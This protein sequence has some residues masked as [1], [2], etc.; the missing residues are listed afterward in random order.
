[1]KRDLYKETDK[2]AQ[3]T[4]AKRNLTHTLS[5]THTHTTLMSQEIDVWCKTNT[6]RTIPLAL[7]GAC[8]P[9]AK[10]MYYVKSTHIYYVKKTY[11]VYKRGMSTLQKRHI[12]YFSD[13]VWRMSACRHVY[14]WHNLFYI[15]DMKSM[16]DTT[17]L[18]CCLVRIRRGKTMPK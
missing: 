18:W 4:E 7:F 15:C 5:L 1:M 10:H 17:K 9:A 16:C 13:A 8:S 3:A 14:L 2:K 12:Y 11:L 6:Q